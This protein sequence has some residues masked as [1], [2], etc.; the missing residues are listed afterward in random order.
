MDWRREWRERRERLAGMSP[1]NRK[2][3]DLAKKAVNAMGFASQMAAQGAEN[4]QIKYET[5]ADEAMNELFELLAPK[6]AERR[7]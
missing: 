4:S 7:R 2:I 3:W 5:Q 1:D 6:A